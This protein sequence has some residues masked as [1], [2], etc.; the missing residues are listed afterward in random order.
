[1][2]I[3]PT[4]APMRVLDDVP[5]PVEVEPSNVSLPSKTLEADPHMINIRNVLDYFMSFDR[6]AQELCEYCAEHFA[7]TSKIPQT[8]TQ[9]SPEALAKFVNIPVSDFPTVSDYTFFTLLSIINTYVY[10]GIFH[11]FHPA[12]SRDDDKDKK[13]EYER[14]LNLGRYLE[15]LRF[16]AMTI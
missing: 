6:E 16:W 5:N 4:V 1:M 12:I 9:D 13:S 7:T 8:T 14:R 10:S 15:I 3:Y 11:P 2:K